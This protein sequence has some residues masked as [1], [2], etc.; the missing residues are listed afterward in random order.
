M[1]IIL[2]ALFLVNLTPLTNAQKTEVRSVEERPLAPCCYTQSIAEHGSEVAWEMRTEV[3]EMVGK[4]R[5]EGEIIEHYEGVYGERILI[6]PD[7]VTGNILF[8][9][10]VAAAVLASLVLFLYVRKMLRCGKQ[11]VTTTQDRTPSV[12]NKFLREK[13]DRETGE[14][15]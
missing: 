7:G 9:L 8:A 10:P 11:T 3:T 2:T 15:F 4:G 14:P 1:K 6:V 12:C 5:T 13:I